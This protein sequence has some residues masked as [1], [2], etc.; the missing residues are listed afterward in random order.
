[1]GGWVETVEGVYLGKHL[2]VSKLLETL[3]LSSGFI[4]IRFRSVLHYHH[5]HHSHDRVR[6]GVSSE[7]LGIHRR[8]NLSLAIDKGL[9]F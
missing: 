7:R 1:M 2:R 4:R 6:V 8:V 9:A 5:H 3:S